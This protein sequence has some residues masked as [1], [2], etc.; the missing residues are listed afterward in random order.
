MRYRCQI[1][2]IVEEL[3]VVIK[4]DDVEIIGF[5]SWG[6]L[7]KDGDV[8]YVDIEIFDEFE[9]KECICESPNI[10]HV[11]GFQYKIKGRFDYDEKKVESLID[12]E[13]DENSL[14]GYEYLDGKMVELNTIRFNMT[15]WGN[16]ED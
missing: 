16:R 3:E 13:L 14:Y 2:K 9:I 15:F 8:C 10:E 4:I 12:F 5:D 1:K 7:F 11:K 6:T